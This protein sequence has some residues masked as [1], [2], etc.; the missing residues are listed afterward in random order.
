MYG[1]LL[2]ELY[3]LRKSLCFSWILLVIGLGIPK[4]FP[5]VI[6]VFILIL[7]LTSFSYDE[8]SHWDRYTNVLP[9]TRKQIVIS[10]YL[11]LIG[12]VF[13][14]FF[15]TISFLFL[16]HILYSTDIPGS[17]KLNFLLSSM[18]IKERL[19]VIPRHFSYILIMLSILYPIIFKL[20][21]KKS[22]ALV[23]IL[24]ILPFVI[25]YFLLA[26]EQIP[27]PPTLE[28]MQT[29]LHL[30]NI[31]APIVAIICLLLSFFIS[32]KIYEKKAF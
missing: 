21:A 31:Y 23:L 29:T 32:T 8:Q 18:D 26:K 27:L 19:E 13:A 24:A 30:I 16:N 10:K 12:Q 3:S 17:I 1:L 7:A 22:Y 11:F 25:I 2:K 9:F 14:I 4:L 20:G 28:A 5:T 6:V 15:I